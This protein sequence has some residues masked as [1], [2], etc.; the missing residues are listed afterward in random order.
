[1]SEIELATQTVGFI[2][3]L[4][5]LGVFVWRVST[6]FWKKSKCFDALKNSVKTTEIDVAEIKEEISKDL[7]ESKVTHIEIFKRMNEIEKQLS[8]IA[9]Q[10]GYKKA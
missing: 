2:I 7:A 3:G 9:G 4:L 8:F 10:L 6:Y 5:T 1:M